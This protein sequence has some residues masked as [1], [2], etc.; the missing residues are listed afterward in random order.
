MLSSSRGSPS[1]EYSRVSSVFNL[2]VIADTDVLTASFSLC[3]VAC[4][5]RNFFVSVISINKLYLCLHFGCWERG[6]GKHTA[7]NFR[8]LRRFGLATT[9]TSTTGW[10]GCGR[11]IEIQIISF[12]HQIIHQIL[13]LFIV[14]QQLQFF[15]LIGQIFTV[16]NRLIMH[17][18][19]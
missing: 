6:G 10:C 5:N 3:F 2:V 13:Q 19:N 8:F 16:F 17:N 14:L 11:G 4:H 18:T 15:S 1:S 7:F 12:R 9:T